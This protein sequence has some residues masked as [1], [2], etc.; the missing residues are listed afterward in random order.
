MYSITDRFIADIFALDEEGVSNELSHEAK[1]CLIDYLGS[2]YA[3]A[4]LIEEKVRLVIDDLSRGCGAGGF[5]VLGTNLEADIATSAFV[6]GMISHAAE[7]DDGVI[8]GIIHPGTPVISAL[9]PV[10]I[11]HGIDGEHLLRGVVIGYEVAVRLA[12]A[13]QPSHKLSGY[14]ATATCGSVGAAVGIMMMLDAPID[15]VKAA[16]SVAA[17][18]AG[19]SLKVLEGE[20]QLKPF[21]SGQAAMSAIV[22]SSMANAG[23][24]A[25]DDALGGEF[26]FLSM[27]S[28]SL[29]AEK[30]FSKT[31]NSRY[32]IEEVYFKPYAACRYC[33]SPIDAALSIRNENNIDF[34]RIRE[35]VV[36]TYSLAVKGHDHVQ[37]SNISSAKM[38]IPFSV[39]QAIVSANVGPLGFTE[40]AITDSEV[41]TLASKIKVK[42][43][44]EHTSCFPSKS[45]ATVKIE[46]EDGHK[47]QETVL[48][49]KGEPEM[50][51]TDAEV[52]EKF[53]ML[54]SFGEKNVSN[55]NKV[56]DAVWQLPEKAEMLYRLL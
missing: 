37:I 19:G 53:I 21:N 42:V 46:M 49:P 15:R 52:S 39:A 47:L 54:A 31:R 18:S 34:R 14:H 40:S 35:V 3:G 36:E 38:S 56:L 32:A 33:H 44:P 5:P 27:M 22:A 26:G 55:C 29:D 4:A 17:V 6:N 1:R 50:R 10:A 11:A 43:N 13:I 41:L 30:L 20:S 23:F 25:P 51:L 12:Q 2:A 24:I 28:P 8:S 9:L 45:P 16:L 7:L 48:Y